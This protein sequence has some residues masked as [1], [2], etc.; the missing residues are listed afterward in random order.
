MTL[1]TKRILATLTDHLVL[2]IPSMILSFALSTV[3]W[4][5][6]LLPGLRIFGWFLSLVPSVSTLLFIAYETVSLSTFGT[7]VGK[8]LFRLKVESLD[9]EM[10]TFRWFLRSAAKSFSFYWIFTILGIFSLYLMLFR[11]ATSSL[12]DRLVRSHV[13]ESLD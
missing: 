2:L 7:T 11:D 10:S 13:H 12:H 3:N 8:R 5:M 4:F 9:G 1:A 6:A